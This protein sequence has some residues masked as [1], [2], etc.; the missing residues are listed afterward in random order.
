MGGKLRLRRLSCL[1]G[2]VG[3]RCP[4]VELVRHVVENEPFDGPTSLDRASLSGIKTV[5]TDDQVIKSLPIAFPL[6]FAGMWLLVT[7][8]MGVMSGWFS[9]QQWYADDGDERAL[10]PLGWGCHGG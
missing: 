3:I 7:T 6:I 4:F 9:L 10:L 5:V 1:G 8:L 2:P